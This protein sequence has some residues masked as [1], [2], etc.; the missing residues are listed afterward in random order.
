MSSR[1]SK[2]CL[3]ADRI[4]GATA[5]AVAAATGVGLIGSTQS[6]NAAIVDSG[7]V[8]IAVPDNI[9]GVYLNVVTGAAGAVAPAGWDINP[10]SAVAGQFNLWGFD[11]TTWRNTAGV[12]GNA[13][14]YLLAPGT[15]IGPPSTGFF[16]PGGGTNVGTAVTLNSD[17]NFLGFEFVNE[18]GATTHYGWAQFQFG[19]T[20]G[21][22]SIVRYAYEGTPLASIDAGVVPEPASLGLLAIGAAGLVIRRR[23]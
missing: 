4:L 22:R 8:N 9:D 21:E 2:V 17:Q 13:A 7:P 19:A 20:A 5:A 11:T 6:A 12:V 16:R 10:Y 14:G 15:P 3:Q 1:T 18:S 23:K